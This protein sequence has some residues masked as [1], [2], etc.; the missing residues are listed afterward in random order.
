[1]ARAVNSGRSGQ[2]FKDA[3]GNEHGDHRRNNRAACGQCHGAHLSV[4]GA[5]RLHFYP[6][7]LSKIGSLA[8]NQLDPS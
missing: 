4:H 8:F 7:T 1:M 6:C 5:V 2:I 3:N